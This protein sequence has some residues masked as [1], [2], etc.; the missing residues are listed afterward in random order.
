MMFSLRSPT[1]AIG[2]T[3]ICLMILTQTGCA[4]L[5]LSPSLAAPPG[6][7]ESDEQ[8]EEVSDLPGL[9]G[10]FIVAAVAVVGGYLLYKGITSD[11]GEEEGEPEPG[12]L[13]SP[14]GCTLLVSPDLGIPRRIEP[15][16]PCVVL[17]PPS[18]SL[19]FAE[20]NGVSSGLA[21]VAPRRSSRQR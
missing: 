16:T 20:A 18:L 7:G 3:L 10:V 11:R 4:T 6:E 19:P 2:V 5:Q 12:S 8:G 17:T 14:A 21:A 9:G 15:M 1:R 13:L